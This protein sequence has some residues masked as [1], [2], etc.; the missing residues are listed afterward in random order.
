MEWTNRFTRSLDYWFTG[1]QVTTLAEATQLIL[2]EHFYELSPPEVKEWVRDWKPETADQAA[3]LT[4][5]FLDARS[6][7]RLEPRLDQPR[8][9][10]QHTRT[11]AIL[12]EGIQHRTGSKFLQESQ[13]REC[14]RQRLQQQ[15]FEIP[16]D[17]KKDV[18]KKEEDER[19][20][21]YRKLPKTLTNWFQAFVIYASVFS[22]RF[23]EQGG[24]LF[25]YLDEIAAAQRTYGGMAWWSY[26]EQFWQ[27][28]SVK[29][30][31]KVDLLTDGLNS[32]KT[33][34]ETIKAYIRDVV[35]K[36]I[37]GS[38][39]QVSP[40]EK[41]HG[42]R[43][44]YREF[45]NACLLMFALKPH[46]YPT[47]R[48]RV[49]T[50]ISYLRGEPRTWA[51]T[52][53]ENNEEILNSLENFFTAM[54]Q[55]YEDPYKQLTAE[56]AM[57]G[58]RQKKRVVEDYITE[59]KKWAKDSQWNNLSLRNQFRLGLSDPIKDELSRIDLPSTLEDLMTLSITIDRRLRERQQERSSHDF[60]YK[61]QVT[62]SHTTSSTKI[63]AEPMDIG[64]VKGPLS[65]QEK[66]R[67]RNLNLC[68]Y[69]ASDD[70]TVKD[71]PS[72]LRQNKVGTTAGQRIRDS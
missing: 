18:A 70:H 12:Q 27:R 68:L 39:P 57:R 46:T 4:D 25:C 53:F 41:F 63:L 21:R 1:C 64:F 34:N 35:D 30:E 32:L 38:E 50:T 71:C 58:L 19:K 56:T 23:P 72:L 28:L 15:S 62:T 22:G 5:Q 29:P 16:E 48:V 51:N 44:Q 61:K 65:P 31:M 67:R 43:S 8:Q 54:G 24:S 66:L 33:E 40:P 10:D 7:V 59:F 45:K 42:D 9:P 2:L 20:K 55:L 17:S 11:A 3:V 14:S 60:S 13:R 6:Q 36:R 49:L 52:F 26:D 69:C 47:D 37:S